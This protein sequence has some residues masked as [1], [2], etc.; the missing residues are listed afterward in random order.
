MWL[1]HKR[2][3]SVVVFRRDVTTSQEIRFDKSKVK[4]NWSSDYIY[5]E[6]NKQII[7]AMSVIGIQNP[8]GKYFLYAPRGPVC[9]F[10]KY[11]FKYIKLYI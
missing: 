3:K 7:A 4:E 5:L 9:D 10:R 11:D 8:N 1:V 2:K 6:E